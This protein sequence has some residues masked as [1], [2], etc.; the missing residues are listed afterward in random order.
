MNIKDELL[1]LKDEKYALFQAK[2]APNIESSTFIGV[3]VPRLREFAKTLDKS[4]K[5]AFI[6]S[7]P[8]STYDENLLHSVLLNNYK[9]YDE[10]IKYVDV[11]LPFVDNWAVCDTLR[12]KVF[13]K[14]KEELIIKI[15]EWLKSKETYTIRFAVDMLM[16]YYLDDDFKI[17]YL[18]IVSKIRSEEY[19]VNMM[20]AWYFATALAKKWEE[21]IPYIENHKLSDW[22]NNKAIQK[23]K[24]SFRISE[25]KKEY[26]NTLKV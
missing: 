5:D 20:I 21:T 15:N 11:F 8:H 6:N 22:T 12:P 23:S 4:T 26:L 9:P 18:E 7:L 17:E 1:K 2:L 3:R 25:D 24:E 19:Y 13:E 10:C 14:H 16:T